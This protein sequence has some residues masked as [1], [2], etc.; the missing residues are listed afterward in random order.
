M[1]LN[2]TATATTYIS[3]HQGELKVKA[4]H[5]VKGAGAGAGGGAMG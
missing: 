2:L 4:E 3:F 5:L 1:L